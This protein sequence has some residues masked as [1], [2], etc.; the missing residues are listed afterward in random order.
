MSEALYHTPMGYSTPGPLVEL[1]AIDRRSILQNAHSIARRYRSFVASY[2]EALSRGRKAAW[3]QFAV[4]RSIQSLNAQVA[5]REFT[6]AQIAASR[7]ATR[8]CGSSYLPM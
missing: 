5:K 4:A 7:A 3:Q 1:P 8:R 6:A 2:A